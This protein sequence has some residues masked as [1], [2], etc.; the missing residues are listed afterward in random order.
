MIVVTGATGQLGSRIVQHLLE[1]VPAEG[2]GVSVR[3]TDAAAE[4][5]DRG[6]RVR[7]GDFADPSTLASAFEG[8]SQVLVVS[9]D[10]LGE[11]A[12][13]AHRVALDAALEAGAQR[14]LYTSHQ[15]AGPDSL[16]EPARDHAATETHLSG[17]GVPF[18][19]LRDGFH[20]S[21]VPRL[22]GAALQTG[23]L[24]AP[25]D[26][27]VSWTTHDDLAEAAAAVLADPDRPERDTSVLTAREAVTL[28][29]V[30]DLLSER[31]GR[32]VRRVVVGDEDYVAGL[33]RHGVPE[34]AA[35]ML[36]TLFLAA[37]RGEFA[38]TAPT[39]AELVGREP[40]PVST[41]LDAGVPA[42]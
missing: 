41:V 36:L 24:V 16:F 20:A 28:E 26:G 19:A 12:V 9:V 15:A 25:E 23:E 14:I 33:V 42:G 37:R 29:Q 11:E 1:R 2:I 22:V 32:T 30:A 10:R 38:V 5:A 6:V 18:T 27:P 8:A 21:T 39:L 31:S 3:D 13:A 17:L 4:L 40:Q 35:R 34:P 7:R